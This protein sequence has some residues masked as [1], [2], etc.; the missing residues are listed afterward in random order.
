MEREVLT[1]LEEIVGR[2]LSQ[3]ADLQKKNETLAAELES[4]QQELD[5]L[6]GKLQEMHGDKDEVHQRLSSILT[7]LEKWEQG[8]EA[9]AEAVDRDDEVGSPAE[10]A[11]T[12]APKQLFNM[13]V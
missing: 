10:A 8:A 6:Q 2:L 1:R 5:H 11:D 13:G 4:K 3:Y 12:E 9:E 7:K